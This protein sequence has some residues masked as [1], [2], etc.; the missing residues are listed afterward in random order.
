MIRE[1][2]NISLKI[3]RLIGHKKQV[4]YNF[5]QQPVISSCMGYNEDRTKASVMPVD[6]AVINYVSKLQYIDLAIEILEFKYKHFTPLLRE[7]RI[8][9]IFLLKKGE[10]CSV[11]V[12]KRLMAEVEEIE[13]AASWKYELKPEL[14]THITDD[15]NENLEAILELLS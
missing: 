13:E 14:A 6:K 8:K 5:N 12:A 2:I 11:N 4:D 10:P 15:V 3:K 1:Y 7:V 9:D